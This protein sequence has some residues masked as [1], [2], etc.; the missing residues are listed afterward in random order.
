MYKPTGLIIK[1]IGLTIQL[2]VKTTVPIQQIQDS[3]TKNKH[4]QQKTN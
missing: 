3:K 2:Y 1:Q 4:N